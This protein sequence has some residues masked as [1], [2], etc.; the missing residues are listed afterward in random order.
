MPC[1][2]ISTIFLITLCFAQSFVYAS[3][4]HVDI[5][6]PIDKHLLILLEESDADNLLQEI[7]EL[8]AEGR[9]VLGI[10]SIGETA[11]MLA[12]KTRQP[13]VA[14]L[15]IKTIE[16][17]YGIK[18]LKDYINLKT[19]YSEDEF[20]G[21]TALSLAAEKG[22]DLATLKLLLDKGARDSIEIPIAAGDT[23]LMVAALH[24]YPDAVKLLLQYGAHINT[25]DTHGRTALMY[26]AENNNLKLVALLLEHGADY[27]L[28]NDDG[29]TA[30]DVAY[31][32]HRIQKLLANYQQKMKLAQEN[33]PAVKAILEEH[34]IPPLA[35]ITAEYAMPS[36]LEEQKLIES[37]KS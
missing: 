34:M 27:T 7:Q 12:I 5:K 30:Y 26:A 35:Q 37:E 2:K 20:S 6:Q 14:K 16:D 36:A 32:H 4:I 28:Q 1:F 19:P 24:N 15:F 31:E 13:K 9:S 18:V 21:Y 11:L 10:N 8:I 29:L 25:Q 3:Q 23:P 17:K 22:N 33:Q